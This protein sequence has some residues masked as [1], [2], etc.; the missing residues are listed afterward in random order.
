MSNTFQFQD[1]LRKLSKQ[2]GWQYSTSNI[3]AKTLYWEIGTEA[4]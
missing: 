4:L 2:I 3:R 1:K